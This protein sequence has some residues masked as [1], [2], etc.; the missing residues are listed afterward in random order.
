MS[1]IPLILIDGSYFIFHRYYA[2]LAWYKI[3]KKISQKILQN[4]PNLLKN[5]ISFQKN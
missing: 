2:L 3:T 4:V 1:K 5:S